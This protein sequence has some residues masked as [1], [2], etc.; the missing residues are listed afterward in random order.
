MRKRVFKVG[1]LH[2]VKLG[3][4]TLTWSL[5]RRVKEQSKAKASGSGS[6]WEGVERWVKG[7]SEVEMVV[8]LIA[9]PLIAAL[10]IQP[11]AWLA[12]SWLASRF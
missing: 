11:V 3:R 6:G 2:F 8:C 4:L 12:E 7:G 1:G 5:S 9:W 10:A